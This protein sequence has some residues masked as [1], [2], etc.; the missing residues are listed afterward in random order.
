MGDTQCKVAE[1]DGN[2]DILI[3]EQDENLKANQ[4]SEEIALQMKKV[5]M[6][7]ARFA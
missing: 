4:E 7:L 3:S 6:S 2:L 1:N 5:A